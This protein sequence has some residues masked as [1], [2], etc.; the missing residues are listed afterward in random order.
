MDLGPAQL[1]EADLLDA[2]VSHCF[3]HFFGTTFWAHGAKMK[4][5]KTKML[6]ERGCEHEVDKT[7]IKMNFQ[8]NHAPPLRHAHVLRETEPQMKM[9]GMKRT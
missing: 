4:S 7:I 8:Q 5:E 1:F 9:K 2:Q 6:H 3:R